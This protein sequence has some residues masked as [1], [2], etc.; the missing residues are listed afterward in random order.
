MLPALS[1]ASASARTIA[2]VVFFRLLYS[3]LIRLCLRVKEQNCRAIIKRQHRNKSSLILSEMS[4][5]EENKRFHC[6]ILARQ[7]N[8]L[9]YAIKILFLCTFFPSSSS[10]PCCF[11]L[12]DSIVCVCTHRAHRFLPS[13]SKCK[14][15]LLLSHLYIVERHRIYPHSTW[16]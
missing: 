12:F 4:D 13:F 7:P 6:C 9:C 1:V 3:H 2:L 14:L 10:S 5:E 11:F 16:S 15:Q 8:R